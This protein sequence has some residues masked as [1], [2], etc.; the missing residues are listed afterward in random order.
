MWLLQG[1]D[2]EGGP[3]RGAFESYIKK[4]LCMWRHKSSAI[5]LG[6][7]EVA[8][9]AD[10]VSPFTFLIMMGPLYY[11]ENDSTAGSMTAHI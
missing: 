10:P 2:L 4:S 3:S 9:D 5:L 11:W 8:V 6:I 7:A 1:L